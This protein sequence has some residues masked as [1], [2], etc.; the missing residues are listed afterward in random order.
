MSTDYKNV[1]LTEEVYETLKRR[2]REDESFSDVVERLV[3]ER[4][5]SDLAGAFSE[6]SVESIREARAASYDVY[7]ARRSK[8]ADSSI[9]PSEETE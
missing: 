9:D 2:K 3:E 1:R 6:R 8:D 5:I 4:P 7:T